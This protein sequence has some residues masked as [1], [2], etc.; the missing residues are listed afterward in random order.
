[1]LLAAALIPLTVLARQN[2]L[3]NAALLVIRG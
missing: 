2:V 1:M 3:A